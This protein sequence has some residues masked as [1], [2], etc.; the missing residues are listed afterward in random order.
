M[1]SQSRASRCLTAL[2]LAGGE[3]RRMGRDKATLKMDGGWLWERQL[4]LLRHLEPEAL[5]VSARAVPEWCPPGVEVVLD[6]APSSGPLSGISA[7][8]KRLR[9]THLLV[10]AVDLPQMTAAHLRELWGATQAGAGVVPAHGDH[11]EPLCAV[12]PRESAV[13]FQEALTA[14]RPAMQEVVRDLVKRKLVLPRNLDES[15]TVLYRNVNTPE[16]L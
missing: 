13:F 15:E 6:A 12:Y 14:R 2:L 16:D 9:T 1:E 3:S 5:W 7:A 10:L 8:M 11:V 4:G